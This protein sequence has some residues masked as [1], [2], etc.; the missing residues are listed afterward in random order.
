MAVVRE[1]KGYWRHAEALA[2]DRHS[3]LA[4]CRMVAR[5]LRDNNLDEDVRELVADAFDAAACGGSLDVELGLKY[6]GRERGRKRAERRLLYWAVTCA[7]SERR[8]Y[9]QNQ[10]NR[11]GAYALVAELLGVSPS[12]VR[13]HFTTEEQRLK[14]AGCAV[15]KGYGRSPY[16]LYGWRD[17]CRQ[18]WGDIHQRGE[19]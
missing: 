7:L 12:T 4:L 5:Q 6:E 16:T 9:G 1:Q 11:P 10:G 13:R 15:P 2:G 14:A 8:G 19:P 18:A 3:A 17:F